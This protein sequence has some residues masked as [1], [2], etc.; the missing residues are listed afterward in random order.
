MKT[1]QIL[2]CFKHSTFH[3]S[4]TP[5]HLP[6]PSFSLVVYMSITATASNA[7]PIS[8]AFAQTLSLHMH[9]ENIT[10]ERKTT[11]LIDLIVVMAA[12]RFVGDR[13]KGGK[14]EGQRLLVENDFEACFCCR[15]RQKKDQAYDT[16]L[17][18]LLKVSLPEY[19]VLFGKML[20]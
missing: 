6:F 20:H 16:I 15:G 19:I 3:S 4:P 17:H 18:Y 11:Y 8:V 2:M 12:R 10:S 1:D 5:P 14:S 13:D 9:R 7:Y